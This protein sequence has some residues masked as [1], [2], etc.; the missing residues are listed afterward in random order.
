MVE[1][2]S[3]LV[4]HCLIEDIVTG[5]TEYNSAVLYTK[6]QAEKLKSRELKEG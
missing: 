4:Y 2:G 5:Y 3:C 1:S 6:K